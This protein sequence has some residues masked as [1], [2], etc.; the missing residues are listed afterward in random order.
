M[1]S[2]TA[3]FLNE[4]IANED[5][6]C[7]L[8]CIPKS[9]ISIRLD[10]LKLT[11]GLS[12]GDAG[13]MYTPVTDK[14][15]YEFELDSSKSNASILVF[16]KSQIHPESDAGVRVRAMER[17]LS[18]NYEEVASEDYDYF[19]HVCKGIITGLRQLYSFLE[20][21]IDDIE[22]IALKALENGHYRN[23]EVKERMIELTKHRKQRLFK[24]KLEQS[25]SIYDDNNSDGE[26]EEFT[27]L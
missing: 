6:I 5:A 16:I 23:A 18:V 17:H 8:A 12:Y 1:N 9:I 10:S 4:M 15:F 13:I 21:H 19:I 2:K 14:F 27:K 22:L 24:M 3:Q 25:L 26:E 11:I 7:S 20:Q